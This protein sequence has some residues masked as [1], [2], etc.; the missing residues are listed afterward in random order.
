M[1][2]PI[3]LQVAGL[4]KPKRKR[5]RPPKKLKTPEELAQEAATKQQ[6]VEAKAV[7]K[8]EEVPGKRRRKTPTRFK[9]AVQV[10]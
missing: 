1:E 9:E 3:A 5:G 7:Q 2:H 6:V 8:Q 10:C 4:E